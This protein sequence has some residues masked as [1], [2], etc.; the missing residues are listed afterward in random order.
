MSWKISRR[1][2][3]V[4]NN[5]FLKQGTWILKIHFNLG[6]HENFGFLQM[7]SQRM[8]QFLNR[9]EFSTCTV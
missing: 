6:L 9:V 3:F 8:S 7:T 2:L 5:R 4:S 1:E